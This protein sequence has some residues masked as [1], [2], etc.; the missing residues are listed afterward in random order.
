MTQGFLTSREGTWKELPA[1][2]DAPRVSRQGV[3]PCKAF[4][5][6]KPLELQAFRREDPLAGKC[7]SLGTLTRSGQSD[8]KVMDFMKLLHSKGPPR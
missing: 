7:S 1:G 3:I 4:H 5:L 2:D 8:L 6:R